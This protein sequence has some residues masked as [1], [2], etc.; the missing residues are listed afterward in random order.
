MFGADAVD[1]GIHIVGI[2]IQAGVEFGAGLGDALGLPG[3]AAP[4]LS[5]SLNGINN[6]CSLGHGDKIRRRRADG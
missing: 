6:R 1:P 3:D 4:P 5:L 2:D